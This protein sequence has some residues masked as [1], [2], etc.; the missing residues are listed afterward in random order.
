MTDGTGAPPSSPVDP[1]PGEAPGK[2]DLPGY[3]WQSV[4][5]PAAIVA[6]AA[7]AL[8]V[9]LLL[10]PIGFGFSLDGQ[11]VVDKRLPMTWGH[12]LKPFHQHLDLV[13]ILIWDRMAVVF[14][15]ASS[16]PY[17]AFLLG[18]H[19]VLATATT[20]A[21]ARRIGSV[22]AVAFGLPLAL[23]GSSYF[24]LI[25][26]WQILFT[27]T[28]LMGLGALWASIA[29]DRTMVR[30]LAVT[31]F[32]VIAIMTSNLAV[33]IT[34]A[35]GLW[36][37][38]DGRRGQL[39]ELA[40][41]AVLFGLWF[42]TYGRTGLASDGQPATLSSI[43]ALI[44][45]T[46]SAIGSGVGGMI[47]L[48]PLAGAFVLGALAVGFRPPLPMLAFLVGIFAMF[49]VAALFRSSSGPEQPLTSR[50]IYLVAYM[51]AFGI[52]AAAYRPPVRPSIALGLSLLAVAGNLWILARELPTY[53]V[54]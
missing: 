10:L 45:Y 27:I 5:V 23:L 3:D 29:R 28:L 53:L 22:F 7:V 32:L 21:L 24:N 44:P 19:V 13:P 54:H 4:V 33:F 12:L 39:L 48:G 35:L 36:F 14:G 6:V 50:Y 47:G 41:A 9:V 17:L 31:G 52:I 46:A 42:L 18:T 40:P 34:L 25:A 16:T 26:P 49:A 30:R 37:V 11:T 51:T 20:A 1:G 15:T 2:V 38:L 8:S 43:L